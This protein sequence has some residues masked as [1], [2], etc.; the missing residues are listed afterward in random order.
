MGALRMILDTRDEREPSPAAGRLNQ[1]GPGHPTLSSVLR[2]IS[3]FAAEG[4]SHAPA[5]RFAKDRTSVHSAAMSRKLRLR[6]SSEIGGVVSD[7]VNAV[8]QLRFHGGSNPTGI[9][10]AWET[11]R[12]ILS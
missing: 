9:Q 11:L 1:I 5:L 10:I 8:N 2:K 12:R 6:A 7:F 3:A 4:A